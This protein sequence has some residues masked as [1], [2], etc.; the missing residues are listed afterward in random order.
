M[1]S[2]L[3]KILTMEMT[4]IMNPMRIQFYYEHRTNQE[5]LMNINNKMI[6]KTFHLNEFVMRIMMILSTRS[7]LMRMMTRMN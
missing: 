7:M 5:I 4:S 6:S 2:F 1:S 3:L